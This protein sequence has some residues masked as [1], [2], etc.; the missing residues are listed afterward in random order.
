MSTTPRVRRWRRVITTVSLTA[1]ALVAG[2]GIASAHVS[3][4][5]SEAS[6]GDEAIK[7]TFRVPTESETAGTT[8]VTVTIPAEHP[9]AFLSVKD[10][11]GWTATS[12]KTTLPTPVT[13]GNTTIK[14]AVTSVTWTADPGTQIG[15]GKF[16]EFDISAGPVPD[17]D[18]MVF[19]ATQTYSDG[20]VVEWNEPTPASGEEPEHP[21]PTL[22]IGPAEEGDAA[23]HSH[24]DAEAAATT[25]AEATSSFVEPA[26]VEPVNTA[27]STTTETSSAPTII[28]VVSLL[29]AAAALLVAAFALR[30]K[31][32]GPANPPAA[33]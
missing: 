11:P 5:P 9:F 30:R 18:S 31:P 4:N 13:E 22:T 20:T 12:T 10:V 15:P 21:A 1:I 14:E 19:T 26:G 2:A 23:G 24:S 16:G 3:V 33:G 6:A 27:A 28:A 25:S 7:L 32:G 29:V 8:A 17:A